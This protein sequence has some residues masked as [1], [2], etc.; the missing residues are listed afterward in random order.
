MCKFKDI[1]KPNNGQT[2]HTSSRLLALIKTAK[3]YLQAG[4]VI[5]SSENG[6]ITLCTIALFSTR[7]NMTFIRSKTVQNYN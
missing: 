4:Q 5:E 6:N 3:C 7:G 1:Y 2:D